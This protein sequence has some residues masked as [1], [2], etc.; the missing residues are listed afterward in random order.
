[1]GHRKFYIPPP[2]NI[3]VG[4]GKIMFVNLCGEVIKIVKQWKPQ[5]HQEHDEYRDDLKEFLER[6]FDERRRNIYA[7]KEIHRI[8]IESGRSLADIGIDDKIGIELKLNLKGSE[9]D[10]LDGQINK[11]TI[12]AQYNCVIV[13]LCGEVSAETV[14]EVKYRIKKRFEG[15]FPQKVIVEVI[16]KDEASIEKTEGSPKGVNRIVEAFSGK[17]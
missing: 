9:I 17:K 13:V 8:T 12:H 1:M 11:F 6:K 3:C 14:A 5:K 4:G 2:Q 10:R 7:S 15:V 16:T